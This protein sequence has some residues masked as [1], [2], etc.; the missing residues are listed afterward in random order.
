MLNL[1][2]CRNESCGG[3]CVCKNARKW[4]ALYKNRLKNG[5]VIVFDAAF[6]AFFA[7]WWGRAT[8]F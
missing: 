8:W 5:L 4:G 7:S 6:T 2:F 1:S 3:A